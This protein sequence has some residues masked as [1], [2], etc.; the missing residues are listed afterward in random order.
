MP[1]V[2]SQVHRSTFPLA[3]V[4]TASQQTPVTAP[5]TSCAPITSLRSS[6]AP[7]ACCLTRTPGTV[8]GRTPWN[9]QQVVVWEK[10]IHQRSQTIHTLT[11]VY[12]PFLYLLIIIT[13]LF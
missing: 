10:T 3:A 9:A 4:Q 7:A 1:M 2:Y 11:P 8:T 5:P 12:D 6:P 13:E